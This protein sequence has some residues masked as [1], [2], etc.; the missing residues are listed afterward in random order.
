M[1]NQGKIEVYLDMTEPL[2]MLREPSFYAVK[3]MMDGQSVAVLDRIA[4]MQ[5]AVK[6]AHEL[7]GAAE[8]EAQKLAD[9]IDEHIPRIRNAKTD[10]TNYTSARKPT[11]GN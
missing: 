4:E 10:G 1:S 7:G 6:R 5:K 3:V 2:F 11:K 9:I 8:D